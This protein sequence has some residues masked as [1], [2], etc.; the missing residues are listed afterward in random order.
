MAALR[1]DSIDFEG[2]LE[3]LPR[4][5]SAKLSEH[6]RDQRGVG[7]PSI[8][9]GRPPDRWGKRGDPV[10][11]AKIPG[12]GGERGI[13][14]MLTNLEN[15][16]A[17]Y[18]RLTADSEYAIG[19]GACIAMWPLIAP[20]HPELIAAHLLR[21]LSR[22]LRPGKHDLAST[23]VTCLATAGGPLGPRGDVA[24]AMGWIG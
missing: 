6:L 8:V 23:A 11:L 24:R 1:M 20:W 18:E 7:T 21:P 19:Y 5:L 4:G 10:V 13:L 9:S 16:L 2:R 15:P 12:T 14:R 22:G 3:R 17:S